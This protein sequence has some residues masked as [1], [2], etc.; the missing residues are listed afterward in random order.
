[1]E[2]H[3]LTNHSVPGG[4]GGEGVGA[5]APPPPLLRPQVLLGPR[6]QGVAGRSQGV[7]RPLGRPQTEGVEG[8]L[9]P[10]RRAVGWPR[11]SLV[12]CALALFQPA[13]S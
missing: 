10:P 13:A 3:Y 5:A 7:S 2:S 8:T 6:H 9:R 4:E 11:N 1:M 12:P